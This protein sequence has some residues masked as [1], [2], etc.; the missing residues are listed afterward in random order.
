MFTFVI[1][2]CSSNKWKKC[3]Q[4]VIKNSKTCFS[5]FFANFLPCLFVDSKPAEILMHTQFSTFC[6][7][8]NKKR[9]NKFPFVSRTIFRISLENIR[10]S[11]EE[12]FDDDIF[13][14][15][16]KVLS[17]IISINLKEKFGDF[18]EGLCK[19]FSFKIAKPCPNH[20]KENSS[21]NFLFS[22]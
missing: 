7:S 19:K 4:K 11:F 5:N 17:R 2:W 9:A 15:K 1:F 3:T 22:S 12:N 18:C 8:S 10:R 21:M 16:L 14:K 20:K 6:L 13:L